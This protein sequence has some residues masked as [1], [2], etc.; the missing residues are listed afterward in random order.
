MQRVVPMLA[1]FLLG[2]ALTW[3]SFSASSAA[4]GAAPG[5]NG[6]GAEIDIPAGQAFFTTTHFTTGVVFPNFALIPGVVG[7]S[8]GTVTR[9]VVVRF[10]ADAYNSSSASRSVVRLR[11]DGGPCIVAGPEL[12]NNSHTGS[13]FPLEVRTWQGVVRTGPGFH[14]YQMCGAV[15][16]AGAGTASW[17]FR[18]LTVETRT[19]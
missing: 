14:T 3:A 16:P 5:V 12:F 2:V 13:G 4:Q 15:F 11:V 6:E 17:G 18:T 8:N 10:S 7:A 19:R 1:V 9:T